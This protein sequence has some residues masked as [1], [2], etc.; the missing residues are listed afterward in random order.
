MNNTH[1]DNN[2]LKRDIKN[3]RKNMADR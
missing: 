1:N 3:L 2:N